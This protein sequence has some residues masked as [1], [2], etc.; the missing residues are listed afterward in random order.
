MKVLISERFKDLSTPNTHFKEIRSLQSLL[1]SSK[2]YTNNGKS[3]NHFMKANRTAN[4]K[5][6][7]DVIYEYR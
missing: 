2:I 4:K 3:L 5:L 1:K 6:H 7:T